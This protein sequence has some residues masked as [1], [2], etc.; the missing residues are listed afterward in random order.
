MITGDNF[1]KLFLM[2]Q[3]AFFCLLV[4]FI[5]F[6]KIGLEYAL[7]EKKKEEKNQKKLDKEVRNKSMKRLATL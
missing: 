5:L 3:E 2:L 7:R 4:C 1:V 6:Y